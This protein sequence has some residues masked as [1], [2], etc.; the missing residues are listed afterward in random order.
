MHLSDQGYVLPTA[1]ASIDSFVTSSSA[2]Q[3]VLSE[4]LQEG[5]FSL[6]FPIA[7]AI[8]ETLS[9][10]CNAIPPPWFS[11]LSIV[12]PLRL[13]ILS[14]PSINQFS[15]DCAA[16]FPYS[17]NSDSNL[18]LHIGTN[19][20]YSALKT[21]V[22]Y[23]RDELA[24]I[25]SYSPEQVEFLHSSTLPLPLDFQIQCRVES[26]F[27]RVGTA[28]T[29]PRYPLHH[30][31]PTI[32]VVYLPAAIP[33]VS[34]IYVEQDAGI[35]RSSVSQTLLNV[36]DM[37]E[38]YRCTEDELLSSPQEC[39]AVLS[40]KNGAL[41]SQSEFLERFQTTPSHAGLFALTLTGL[42]VITLV[43]DTALYQ[44][45]PPGATTRRQLY[46]PDSDLFG[47]LGNDNKVLEQLK[48]FTRNTTVAIRE[49]PC[50][51]N[52]VSSDGTV[53]SV[54]T[55]SFTD[56]CEAE[57]CTNLPFSVSNYG[58]HI[59]SKESKVHVKPL[60]E[61]LQA[62]A[63][64]NVARE[65]FVDSS[66]L[67][68]HSTLASLGLKLLPA[69]LTCPPACPQDWSASLHT[70]NGFSSKGVATV[71]I[72]LSPTLSQGLS[73]PL[74]PEVLASVSGKEFTADVLANRIYNP[75]GYTGL[76]YV[77]QCEGDYTNLETGLCEDPSNPLSYQCSW[78]QA[79]YCKKCP[80]GALCP[81][82]FRIWPRKGYWVSHEAGLN[83][84][85]YPC[86]NPDADTRCPGWPLDCDQHDPECA[87]LYNQ[88]IQHGMFPCGRGYRTGSNNCM[89]C[90]TGYYPNKQGTCSVC[91]KGTT[92]ATM[93]LPLLYFFG[94]LLLL[95]VLLLI[96]IYSIIKCFGGNVSEASSKAIQFLLW[97]WM[98]L[99]TVVQ[100]TRSLGP[101]APEWL[102]FFYSGLSALQFEGI[103]AHPNCLK[104]I[105]F[106][107][108]WSQFGV[109]FAL[110]LLILSYCLLSKDAIPKTNAALGGSTAR[111]D[112]L[113]TQVK[114]VTDDPSHTSKDKEASPKKW[115]YYL[116]LILSKFVSGILALLALLYATV[117]NSALE[118]VS[119][120]THV[121]TIRAY[122]ALDSDGSTAYAQ[123]DFSPET[124]QRIV[125]FVREGVLQPSSI[126]NKLDLPLMVSTMR[127]D[128][129]HVCYEGKHFSIAIVSWFILAVYAVGYPLVTL[130]CSRKF[131]ILY[132]SKF[133]SKSD[134]KR[135]RSDWLSL[136]SCS[137]FGCS[138]VAKTDNETDVQA[139][140]HE[141]K[142]AKHEKA[143][144][145]PMSAARNSD[146]PTT[147]DST[148]LAYTSSLSMSS[149]QKSQTSGR[150]SPST[151]AF[152]ENKQSSPDVRSVQK[153]IDDSESQLIR[154]P[155]LKSLVTGTYRPSMYCFTQLDQIV[156]L[157]LGVVSS[158]TYQSTSTPTNVIGL[159]ISL[160]A[161]VAAAVLFYKLKPFPKI[162][163]WKRFVKVFL[164]SLVGFSL[165]AN[166]IIFF[167]Y[168]NSTAPNDNHRDKI[169]IHALAITCFILCM[170]LL[171][172][173]VLAFVLTVI[174]A[175]IQVTSD[176][177]FSDK[178]QA[179]YNNPLS[180]VSLS[181]RTLHGR[182]RRPI[183]NLLHLFFTDETPDEPVSCS[184][185]YNNNARLQEMSSYY[186]Q[187]QDVSAQVGQQNHARSALNSISAELTDASR[188]DLDKRLAPQ[189]IRSSHRLYRKS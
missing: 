71:G 94:G 90:D 13:C 182:P 56:L 141:S 30:A 113:D 148:S 154:Q 66:A 25:W 155:L 97:S 92:W 1:P 166:F 54:T 125:A 150:K 33:A 72:D 186:F 183:D 184:E 128:E 124:W 84:M 43:A 122:F 153:I 123:Y 21:F 55:P 26:S 7:P 137:I 52:W 160:P 158:F 24:K 179:F 12:S 144:L 108:E 78:G 116:N 117:T 120:T 82:G 129:H 126:M 172:T 109:I 39:K 69:S 93:L 114:I 73:I 115:S 29:S 171:L 44:T 100:A 37:L 53:M 45:T 170:G 58:Y 146:R 64:Q 61:A 121:S 131:A 133:L 181:H 38:P 130:Y 157:V 189:K 110:Y 85:A 149:H 164:Y 107:T 135:L 75:F 104:S 96:I 152:S 102:Y 168:Y 175:S 77:V 48:Y 111:I 169:I 62:V 119:C 59:H 31:I 161:T 83:G 103:V 142:I 143:F 188:N 70:Y 3:L 11:G 163:R 32:P 15:K 87:Y 89:Q 101:G 174:R 5:K 86:P 35:F 105:P 80:T 140:N 177:Q 42:N 106:Q 50:T 23:T 16:S 4:V 99:Q 46:L 145:N 2:K 27:R 63:E 178:K 17:I 98:S 180:P 151:D 68:T 136:L 74:A 176:S 132:L 127:T 79:D 173:L 8:G 6:Q 47:T 51:V 156:L 139:K 40:S 81:G 91:P 36:T 49:I 18:R 57:V 162:E 41:F 60:L 9:V 67:N 20:D 134:A 167:V 185:Q 147:S 112:G 65:F 95:T 187:K 76:N 138:S 118:I 22:Q 10:H 34:N 159:C 88:Y 28:A 14:Y 19:I 165:V